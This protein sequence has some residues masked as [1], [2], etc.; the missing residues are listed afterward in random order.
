M[1][2]YTAPHEPAG[3]GTAVFLLLRGVDL[4]PLCPSGHSLQRH[5]LPRPSDYRHRT[6]THILK[7]GP[8]T[9]CGVPGPEYY[10]TKEYQ[11]IPDTVTDGSIFATRPWR[12]LPGPSS[13]N[14]VAP[15]AIMLRIVC[16]QLKT[17]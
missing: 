8:G 7:Y 15:S 12:T 5:T 10:T 13:T 4:R 14:S 16:V 3:V 9:P 17:L 11:F 6:D 2:F 1:G